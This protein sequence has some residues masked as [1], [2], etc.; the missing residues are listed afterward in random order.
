MMSK[1]APNIN[2]RHAISMSCKGRRD[3]RPVLGTRDHGADGGKRRE[4]PGDDKAADDR[5]VLPGGKERI[6][7]GGRSTPR[8]FVPRARRSAGLYKWPSEKCTCRF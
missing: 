6:G 8:G 4:T 7:T 3:R 2:T 5:L 1:H